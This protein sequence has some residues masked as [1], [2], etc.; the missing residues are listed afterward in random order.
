M[1]QIINK[2]GNTGYYVH[3]WNF[4]YTWPDSDIGRV[5][6][7]EECEHLIQHIEVHSC[8]KKVMRLKSLR[9]GNM[10]THRQEYSPETPIFETREEAIAHA[11]ADYHTKA[12][13]ENYKFIVV[14][15]P[16]AEAI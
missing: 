9:R 14:D 16:Y 4:F 3:N 15:D 2:K 8:G 5:R 13:S 11:E 10:E 6:D 1:N 12:R 7:G